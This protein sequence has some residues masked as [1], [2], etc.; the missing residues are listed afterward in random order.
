M[1]MVMAKPSRATKG[2]LEEDVKTA[3]RDVVGVSVGLGQD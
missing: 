3:K 1:S 2:L